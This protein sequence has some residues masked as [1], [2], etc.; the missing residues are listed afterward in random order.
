MRKITVKS[1][2]DNKSSNHI[3]MKKTK[4][5]LPIVNRENA[6]SLLLLAMV[7]IVIY[8]FSVENVWLVDNLFYKF[9][10][11]LAYHEFGNGLTLL[12]EPVKNIGDIV[13]SQINHYQSWGGRFVAQSLVQLF[14]AILGQKWFALFNAVIYASLFILIMSIAGVDWRNYKS[15]LTVI[16]LVFTSF[17][18]DISPSFQINYIWMFTLALGFVKLFFT[19]INEKSIVKLI[20]L[21][22]YSFISGFGHEGL[23]VGIGGAII[24]YWL[25]N[26][27]RFTLAE[28]VMAI[29]FGAGC[30]ALCLAPGNF[31]RMSGIENHNNIIMSVINLLV[32]AR[33]ILLMIVV[34]LT[35][36]VRW[37][38]TWR[39]IYKQN[40]F[41]FNVMI[42]CLLFC[43]V[44]GF[45]GGRALMG[46]ELMAIIITVRI[47]KNHSFSWFWLA[48]F[49]SI[50]VSFWIVQFRKIEL[51]R[52]QYD[53]IYSQYELSKDG[54]VYAD[55]CEVNCSPFELSYS[56][57]IPL[58][59][60]NEDDWTLIAF[61]KYMQS[62]YDKDKPLIKVLPKYLQG[63]D[64][65]SLDS[66]IVRCGDGV[67]LL[68]TSKKN[69]ARF[70][71]DRVVNLFGV[72]YRSYAP[73]EI[74]ID[75]P[76]KD[77]DLWSAKVI[78]EQ[79]YTIMN[80]SDN[81]FY[82]KTSKN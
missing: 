60:G 78:S 61:Q 8:A 17:I 52:A 29:G 59:F 40:R 50:L 55:L 10:F 2:N 42:T 48:V 47:L 23:N 25:S 62:L 45:G 63:K 6:V 70:Y 41:Y 30:A 33:T 69:P 38:L 80:L 53:D 82:L 18:M 75:S 44:L 19:Y 57:V 72:F 11:D 28:Y 9:K 77:T 14:C 56:S 76:T 3:M 51:R 20:V 68:V 34:A 4:V 37:K 54:Y 27:R 64:G 66:Q 71:V 39:N 58:P 1:L 73:S 32:S 16:L 81:K 12:T 46:A 67:Y 26:I 21:G 22:L 35:A 43:L 13:Q 49:G 24:V 74:V 79:D 15:L 7:G 31:V 36:N 65:T 5:I